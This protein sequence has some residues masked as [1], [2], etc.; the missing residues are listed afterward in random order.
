MDL[1]IVESPTKAKTISRFLGKKYT[2]LASFG[3]IRD[4]PKSK[5]GVDVENNFEPTYTIPVDHKPKVTALKAAAKKA[6][7]ILLATDEDREG[8]AISWHLANI[9]GVEMDTVQRITFHEITEKAIQHALEHPRKLDMHLIDAQQGRRILDRLV[10]YELSPFLWRKI[11]R[12]LSAGR[13]QSVAVRIIVDREREIIAFIPEEYW[14]IEGEFTP[15]TEENTFS[16][17]LHSLN[18]KKLDKMALKNGEE[19]KKIVS[20]ILGKP[21]TITS[22]E[23]KERKTSP[24]PPFTTSTLQQ[25]AN[26]RLGFSAKQ[27]MTIAQ[28]LYEGKDIGDEGPVGLITYMRTDSVSVSTTFIEDAAGY[29][30]KEFGNEY[31][32]P[33]PRIYKTKSKGAQEAHEAIRPTDPARTP[34]S[35]ETFLDPGEY[36]LYKLIWARA[37]ATQMSDAKLKGMSAD[38]SSGAAVFRATGQTVIFEGYLKL[39]PDQDKDKFLPI[40]KE[41]QTVHATSIEP[42]Q[43]FTEPPPRFTDASLVKTLEEAGIGRPSTYAPTISTIIDREYVERDEKKRLFP[44]PTGMEV[45]DVLM[46]HFPDIVDHEFTSRMEASLDKVAEGEMEWR[47]LMQAFYGPFHANMQIQE[48]A[49]EAEEQLLAKNVVC[50]KC[51]KDM[52]VTRGRFGKFFACTDYPECKGTKPMPGEKAR[53]AP[54]PT[55]IKCNAC[56]DGMM[57]KKIGRFGPFLACNTYPACKNIVNIEKPI[58]GKDGKSVHCPICAEGII[59]ERQSKKRKIFFACNTYPACQQAFWDKPTGETCPTCS[60]PTLVQHGKKFIKCPKEGCEYKR[61]VEESEE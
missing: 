16:A 29:V 37:I 26:R 14:S 20:E 40:L 58:I 25:D 35:I 49:F 52:K 44:T 21:F 15:D 4:L 19:T 30:K 61:P 60:Y 56:A 22:L 31:M 42:K 5:L 17:Q 2:V 41:G 43:H 39:Y 55:D 1:V 34:E 10:G 57:V 54:E 9:L 6:K 23:A 47:P 28:H 33:E 45:T 53:P 59:I 36:K 38:I 11:R 48:K 13:V 18:G 12:G 7:N 3:H 46:K 51:G 32:S 8:E 27:T 50:P 24:P